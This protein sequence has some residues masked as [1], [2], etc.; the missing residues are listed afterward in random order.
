ML[1]D[2]SIEAYESL[3]PESIRQV[4][5]RIL[6]ALGIIK[7][8]NFEAIAAQMCVE[9]DIVW[10]RLSELRR[11]KKIHRPGHKTPTKSG[12]N[13]FVYRLGEGDN[14]EEVYKKGT[15]TAADHAL[16]LIEHKI[17]KSVKRDIQIEW[18]FNNPDDLKDV[19]FGGVKK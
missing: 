19:D 15:E 7:E 9:P 11:D 13:A 17:N 2:T 4:Y 14:T 10:K 8:G 12:R 1:P 18:D 16:N 6:W 3:E 5:E